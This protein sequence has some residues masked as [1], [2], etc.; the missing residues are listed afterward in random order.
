VE[1][2]IGCFCDLNVILG[3]LVVVALERV[4]GIGR[5]L[6]RSHATRE[7]KSKGGLFFVL[8]ATMAGLEMLRRPVPVAC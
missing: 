6:C 7:G 8:Q 5:C 2:E 1:Q 3:V 4:K